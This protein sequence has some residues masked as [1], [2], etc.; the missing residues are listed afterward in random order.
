MA[1]SVYGRTLDPQTRYGPRDEKADVNLLI[2]EYARQRGVDPGGATTFN[3]GR[4]IP[5]GSYSSEGPATVGD[6]RDENALLTAAVGDSIARKEFEDGL[7]MTKFYNE[8]EIAALTKQF[9]TNKAYQE[10]MQPK[11]KSSP[12]GAIGTLVGAFIGNTVAPGAG[13]QIG[14]SIGGQLGSNLG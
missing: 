4:I 11:K 6:I 8:N 2:S 1:R 9:E 7:A 3:A 10:S 14:A 5:R 13:A 12:W